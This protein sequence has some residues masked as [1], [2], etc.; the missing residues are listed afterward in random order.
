MRRFAFVPVLAV[1]G[2]LLLAPAA[3]ATCTP[4]IPFDRAVAQAGAVWW[5][6]VTDA[7]VTGR[8]APGLWGLT[9]RVLDVLKGPGPKPQSPNAVIG[10][11]FV[12]SCG[13]PLTWKQVSAVAPQF[14][15]KTR[16]FIGT[17][18]SGAL[19]TSPYVYAEGMAPQQQY[20]RALRDLGLQR[21]P[22]PSPLAPLAAGGF[23]LWVIVLAALVVLIVVGLFVVA[24][25]RRTTV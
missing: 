7:G 13:P 23:P 17:Y 14:V 20:Q 22:S 5:G 4:G 9:V 15:G 6:T 10:T 12:S 2:L 25:R 8:N 24:R 21:T 19:V 18:G 16:L 11:V 3:S 1:S